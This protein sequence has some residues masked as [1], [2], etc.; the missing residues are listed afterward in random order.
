LRYL[1]TELEEDSTM[2]KSLWTVIASLGVLAC[3]AVSPAHAQFQPQTNPAGRPAVSP[4]LNLLRGGNPAVNYYG[5]VR[6][7]LQTQ[8]TLQQLQQQLAL[9]QLGLNTAENQPDL[10]TGHAARFGNF[11]H[12]Y[13]G[14]N[15]APLT[16]PPLGVRPITTPALGTN[17][18]GARRGF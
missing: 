6:P 9:N 14:V 2:K 1:N 10:T 8:A 16:V 12:Y 17:P 7:Q 3:V 18:L 15:Q 13:G 4:F 11:S 5:L